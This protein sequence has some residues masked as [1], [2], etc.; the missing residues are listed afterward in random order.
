MNSNPLIET[1]KK[2]DPSNDVF[3][4]DDGLPRLDVLSK[5]LGREVTRQELNDNVPGFNRV[6]ASEL[7]SADAADASADGSA[8]P[9]PPSADLPPAPQDAVADHAAPELIQGGESVEERRAQL[10]EALNHHVQEAA[11]H[12]QLRD[13]AQNELSKLSVDHKTESEQLPI[14]DF[15]AAQNRAR[16]ERAQLAQSLRGA[17]IDLKAIHSAISPAPV[18][19]ARMAQPNAMRLR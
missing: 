17:G 2:L 12:S 1:L 6:T 19:A 15:L 13:E 16:E 11:R 18:D 3:W 5:A 14:A 10:H 7:G 4:T 9:L 8:P